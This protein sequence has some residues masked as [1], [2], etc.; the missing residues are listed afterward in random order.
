MTLFGNFHCQ[1]T[2]TSSATSGKIKRFAWREN[3]QRGAAVDPP[4]APPPSWQRHVILTPWHL[5]AALACHKTQWSVV[6]KVLSKVCRPADL[7]YRGQKNHR[8]GH[9]TCAA[10]MR[11][12]VQTIV[13][14]QKPDEARWSRLAGG[15]A[16]A[17]AQNQCHR[18]KDGDGTRAADSDV[19]R[20]V[21]WLQ[22]LNATLGNCKQT[23]DTS[24]DKLNSRQNGE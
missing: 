18:N 2:A 3:E 23:H 17:T 15:S 13:H 10:M 24:R 21:S 19:Y 14:R 4:L 7:W 5:A 12:V 11:F 9:L 1:E 8:K 22:R 6:T 20:I 16:A